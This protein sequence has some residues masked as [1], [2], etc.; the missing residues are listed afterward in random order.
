[1]LQNVFF[2]FGLIIC[3]AKVN[4]KTDQCL[5]RDFILVSTWFLCSVITM[6]E[7]I[8]RFVKNKNFLIVIYYVFLIVMY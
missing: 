5:C 6:T 3:A 2:P 1:M 7:G 8:C 4:L